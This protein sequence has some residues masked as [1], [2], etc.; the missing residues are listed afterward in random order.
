MD[1]DYIFQWNQPDIEGFSFTFWVAPSTLVFEKPTD[2]SFEIT[3]SFDDKWLEIK[4]IE[5]N[6][7]DKKRVW[8]IITGQGEIA[9]KADAYTQV[10]KRKPSY[11]LGQTVPYD[12][13]GGFNFDL[14]QGSEQNSELRPEIA[15]RRKRQ[16]EEL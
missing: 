4:D 1:I 7:M 15:E 16:F 8:T 6:L 3:Q 2:L 5:M 10:V 13:R 12:E 11:Q 9:F 14:A